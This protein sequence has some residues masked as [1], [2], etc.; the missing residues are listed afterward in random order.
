MII[1][2]EQISFT[3][4]VED[5]SALWVCNVC[6]MMWNKKWCEIKTQ[7]FWQIW[8]RET[9]ASKPSLESGTCSNI[10]HITFLIVIIICFFFLFFSQYLYI[11]ICFSF[12]PFLFSFFLTIFDYPPASS[13]PQCQNLKINALMHLI[14]LDKY[15]M[16][17]SYGSN[18]GITIFARTWKVHLFQ[19]H[20]LNFTKCIHLIYIIQEYLHN[21]SCASYN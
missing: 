5:C 14:A 21:V 20:I 19:A 8:T 17:E 4:K 18:K 10:L 13:C 2:E 12:F 9:W 1:N 16:W 11:I 15:S 7:L 3:W 6:K